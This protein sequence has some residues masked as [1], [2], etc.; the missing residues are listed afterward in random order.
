MGKQTL[1]KQHSILKTHAR[2]IVGQARQKGL[3]R[4]DRHGALKIVTNVVSSNR[5]TAESTTD[6]TLLKA[7]C[8]TPP[9]ED[10]TKYSYE[11]KLRKMTRDNTKVQEA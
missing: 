7:A 4:G 5:L 1:V 3:E 8:R 11:N 10:G 9:V 2:K 6:G